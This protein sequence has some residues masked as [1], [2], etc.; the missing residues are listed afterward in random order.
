MARAASARSKKPAQW[1]ASRIEQR[2]LAA[3]AP[4]AANARTHSDAQVKQI[5]ESIREFGFVNPILVDEAGEIIAGHGRTLAA[6]QLG[7][8]T[9][10]VIQRDGLTDA[11]KRALRLADN[12]LAMN[13]GWD[14]ALLLAELDALRGMDFDLGLTGFDAAEIDILRGI[15]SAP[16]PPPP[17]AADD[18]TPDPDDEDV[19]IPRQR[20][21]RTG[22]M[23][24]LGGHRLLCGDSTSEADVAR[25]VAGAPVALLFTSPP[26]G[27]QR[28]YTTGGI[29]DWDVLMR[30]V[31]QH[32]AAAVAPAGQVLV[33]LGMTH[34]DSEWHPYWQD[35]IEWMR[36]SGWRR[37]GWYVWDQ[38]PGLPGDW[39]GRFS[40]SFEF[41]FHFNREPRRPNKIIESKWAGDPLLM[42]GL[43]KA[44]GTMSGNSHHGRDI[45][46]FRIP[47]NIVRI[48]RHKA[49]GIEIEHPAVFPVKLPEFL[50]HAFT[51]PGEAV[52]EPFSGSGTTI[53]AAQRS[54]RLARAMELAPEY[55]DLTIARWQ[56]LHPDIPVTLDGDGRTYA[57]IAQERADGVAEERANG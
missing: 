16:P 43:R 25:L 57:A 44:D 49:R 17:P 28:N 2:S 23:W 33:N 12:K 13:A 24:L 26:Y 31:F 14:D 3:L 22:D 21:T 45:Q 50:I 51:D 54:A 42:S 15:E 34:H 41:I 9:V 32:A 53:M 29:G 36:T 55:V 52:L 18:G 38:G 11:Q 10:P 56:L 8:A 37:F 40:P 30:G 19:A 1:S 20:V 4:Y 7:L 47:D 6:Q 48:T 27:Q 39:N 46:P 35:W 5:A